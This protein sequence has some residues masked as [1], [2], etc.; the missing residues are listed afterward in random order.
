M[1]IQAHTHANTDIRALLRAPLF[2]DRY[3][4]HVEK[5]KNALWLDLGLYYSR[6]SRSIPSAYHREVGTRWR[7]NVLFPVGL[8][9]LDLFSSADLYFSAISFNA[10]I[11]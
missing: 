2:F 9:I 1:Y 11:L 7:D 3:M 4:S 8:P 10:I 5:M 6:I